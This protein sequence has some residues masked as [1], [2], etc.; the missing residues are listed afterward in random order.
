M[1]VPT[2][3]NGVFVITFENHYM[4]SVLDRIGGQKL[5]QNCGRGSFPGKCRGGF[6]EGT[7]SCNA[8]ILWLRV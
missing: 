2:K 7:R 3:A 1:P 8:V 4:T 5:S 6:I